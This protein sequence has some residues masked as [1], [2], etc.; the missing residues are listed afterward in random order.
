MTTQIS[1]IVSSG[2]SCIIQNV[3]VGL[4]VDGI[5]NIPNNS[6]LVVDFRGQ[7][8]RLLCLSGSNMSNVGDWISPEGR[9]LD[10]VLNDPFDVI[11]DG[12]NNPG[13][14]LVETPPTNSP[15]TAAHQ[16]VYT[17]LMPDEDEELQYL[18][19]GL[20]LNASELETF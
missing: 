5:G 11:F 7:I 13:Q 6:I 1:V 20:Y 4:V 3:G 15:L 2:L 18:Y 14:L 10:A 16:G 19:I 8:P 9:N 12:N 17:C